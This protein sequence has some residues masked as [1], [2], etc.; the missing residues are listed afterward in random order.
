MAQI[1]IQLNRAILDVEFDYKLDEYSGVYDIYTRNI[2]ISNGNILLTT[3]YKNLSSI[4]DEINRLFD[5]EKDIE[6]RRTQQIMDELD[7][8]RFYEENYY[9]NRD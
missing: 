4:S 6:E 7:A 5:F 3:N 2:T 1:Q 8:E 9:R